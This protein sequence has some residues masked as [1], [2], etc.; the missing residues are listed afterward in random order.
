LKIRAFVF[1]VFTVLSFFNITVN[2]AETVSPINVIN[3]YINDLNNN[4]WKKATPWW[5]KENRQILLDFIANKG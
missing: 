2:G 5:D 4:Q 3:N 1:I